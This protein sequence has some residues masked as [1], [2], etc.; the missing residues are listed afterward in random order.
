MILSHKIRVLLQRF[1]EL[2]LDNKVVYGLGVEQGIMM[3]RDEKFGGGYCWSSDEE[4]TA[5]FGFKTQP[6]LLE[7]EFEL[8]DS[9]R[10]FSDFDYFYYHPELTHYTVFRDSSNMSEYITIPLIDYNVLEEDMVFQYSLILTERELTMY[11]LSTYLKSK[12]ETSIT[13]RMNKIDE[14]INRTYQEPA[15]ELHR[16]NIS[17]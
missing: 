17:R 3:V 12:Y 8:T 9:V 1:E 10:Y 11:I 5:Y 14:I 4:H 15:N 16:T 7:G 6:E 2:I 13:L